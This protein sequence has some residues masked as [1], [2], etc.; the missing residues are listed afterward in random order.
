MLLLLNRNLYK[1]TTTSIVWCVEFHRQGVFIGV[2][3]AVTDLIKPVIH[4]VLASR[5][6]IERGFHRLQALDSIPPSLGE[7]HRQGNSWEAAK[8][9]QSAGHP[10]V[11]HISG[12]C[13]RPSRVRCIPRVTL[14][15]V[16]FLISL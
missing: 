2:P 4:Q 11:P 1:W 16:E 3:R 5:P 15:L 9:G 6:A 10:L 8:W 7:H 12:L 14:I 13:R